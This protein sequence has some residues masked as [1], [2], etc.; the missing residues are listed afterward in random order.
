MPDRINPAIR[1]SV[2][3]R[4]LNSMFEKA[5]AEHEF[6]HRVRYNIYTQYVIR[7]AYVV[8]SCIARPMTSAM[9]PNLESIGE[10]EGDASH[11][12]SLH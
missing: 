12:L 5:T 6:G 8:V 11:Y 1:A 9:I 2:S 3:L 4:H 7:Y 10:S